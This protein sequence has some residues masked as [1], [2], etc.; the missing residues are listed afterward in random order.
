MTTHQVQI[1]NDTVEV[2]SPE[3]QTAA[4]SLDAFLNYAQ[5]I[6]DSGS[7]SLPEG[8]AYIKSRGNTV[9]W[10]HQTTPRVWN[11][12]WIAAESARPYGGATYRDVVV[13]LPYM[14]VV[15]VFQL[16]RNGYPAL[17]HANECFFH[18]K[19]LD[20]FETDQMLAPGLLNC[21]LFASPH[22]R[23]PIGVDGK[24]VVWICTQYLKAQRP[25]KGESAN[26][27]MKRS[28]ERLYETLTSTGFNYSSDHHE[29]SSCFTESSAAIIEA[30]DRALGG[31]REKQSDDPRV[32]AIEAWQQGTA[33]APHDFGTSVNWLPTGYTIAEIVE[34]I[35][36]HTGAG[37]GVQSADDVARIVFNNH[38]KESTAK[39]PA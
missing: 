12:K 37:A 23:M 15:A 17:T 16:G 36:R 28:F 19:P 30:A 34:R 8:I 25:T 13:A 6:A 1:K 11:L 24:S 26:Q 38:R 14:S 10:V 22:D 2:V 27:F 32:D 31:K 20:N 39:V 5:G 29:F 33:A 35:F 18:N 4:M 3:G 21:S 9:V 7:A